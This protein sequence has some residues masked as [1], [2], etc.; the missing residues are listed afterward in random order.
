MTF[1]NVGRHPFYQFFVHLLDFVSFYCLQI[2]LL[3]P[4]SIFYGFRHYINVNK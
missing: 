1:K 2:V 4:L 3:A